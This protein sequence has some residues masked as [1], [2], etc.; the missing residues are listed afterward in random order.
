MEYRP[1]IKILPNY[2][3]DQIKA[4]EVI[5]GP[6]SLIKELLENSIDAK[7]T[8]IKIQVENNGL[9]LISIEDNGIGIDYYNLPL[10]FCRHAT[11]KIEK[12]EDLYSLGTFGFRGE[13]LASIAS[14]S[15]VT[16]FSKPVDGIGGK[17]SFHGGNLISHISMKN[18]DQGTSISVRDLF[19]NTPVRFKFIKSKISEKN[20]ISKNI[21]SF[22]ISNPEI[23]FSV[24]W[25]EKDK[26][27]FIPSNW[28]DRVLKVLPKGEY[29][30]FRGEYEG[31]QVKGFIE[32]NSS[33]GNQ[34]NHQY[35]FANNR[36]F[37]DRSLH[38]AILNSME[39]IWKLSESG[40]YC[41]FLSTEPGNLDVN[42]HPKKTEIKFIH[43]SMVFSLLKSS[44]KNSINK[45]KDQNLKKNSGLGNFLE[46]ND[47]LDFEK[48]EINRDPFF[49][50]SQKFILIPFKGKY[51]VLNIPLLLL[52]FLKVNFTNIEESSQIPLLIGEPYP[53]EKENVRF[54]LKPL[55]FNFEK[56]EA[57]KMILLGI[58]SYLSELPFRKIVGLILNSL[59]KIEKEFDVFPFDDIRHWDLK[60]SYSQIKHLIKPF[61]ENLF[62]EDFAKVLEDEILNSLF[63]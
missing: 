26:V 19:F 53:L 41:I 6:S 42:V 21:N 33:K 29:K 25:D 16:T 9:D 58:P 8:Q 27:I 3:I 43:G 30:K 18:L 28:E 55:G 44:I 48:E 39:G 4:G 32:I 45:F 52:N 7:S 17:I 14:I 51:I 5:D 56:I 13:A 54:F 11:S 34:R 10:A 57:S 31:Y 1:Q 36:P 15:R 35:L 47:Q 20:S 12:F 37:I 61:E 38:G 60:V 23:W 22:I 50:I 40:N 62:N 49:R 24:K 63:L 2:L 46:N 59:S